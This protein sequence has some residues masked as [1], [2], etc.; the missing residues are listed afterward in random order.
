[1]NPSSPPFSRGEEEA[2]PLSSW[3]RDSDY[4]NDEPIAGAFIPLS[5]WE[6]DR[7]RGKIARLLCLLGVAAFAAAMRA[8]RRRG[9]AA[10]A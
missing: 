6:R 5:F 1:V 9:V 4:L 8:A 2:D 3:E 10:R 7:V